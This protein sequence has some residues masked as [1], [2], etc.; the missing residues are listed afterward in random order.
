MA[1]LTWS[2]VRNKE[3]ECA[4]FAAVHV[5]FAWRKHHSSRFG[6]LKKAQRNA[7]IT[8]SRV[9]LHLTKIRYINC[10]LRM[11]IVRSEITLIMEVRNTL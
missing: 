4:E 2:N 10:F 3:E 5:G 7:R 1:D 11:E 9:H 8:V 6:Q